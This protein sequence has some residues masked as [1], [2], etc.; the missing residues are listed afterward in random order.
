MSALQEL[1]GI[2]AHHPWY[3]DR[4]RGVR[5]TDWPLLTKADLYARLASVRQQPGGRGG[6]YYSRSG[7]TTT[8]QPLYFPTDVAENHEQ[9]RRLARR[10]VAD[11]VLTP[12]TVAVNICPIV[13]MYRAMEI[14]NEFCECC[15]A[16]VLPMAAI[17]G[18]AEIYEQAMLFAANTLLGMPSRMVAFGRYV[19][20]HQLH[21]RVDRVVFGGEFLQ[22]GKRR[23][24][25]DVFGVRHFSGVYGSAELGVVAWHPDLPEVPVYHFPKDILHVEIL[26]PDADGYGT[27]VATNL[28]RRRFPIVRYHTGDM[29]RIVGEGPDTISVE[30]RGRQSDS[31]LMGDNYHSLADFADLFQDLA[32]YQIQIH[33]DERQRKDVI[34]FCL[35]AGTRLATEGE[36]R[37]LAQRI[38]E[39][40]DGHE[41]MYH[42]EV[43]FVGPEGLLRSRDNLKTP[44]IVD[45]RGR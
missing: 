2:A 33:F 21:W 7:G 40:L 8:G 27:L 37:Q 14:F 11:G 24:L 19:Q 13:R 3:H 6:I 5:L 42:T 22:P 32:E 16:T 23:F 41:L 45:R 12:Q 1:L 29:G 38:C 20:E 17:A 35:N 34:R 26:A 28:V 10:L 31:F 36:R 15:G 4:E 9:R 43:A 18:D 30:L 25:H 39:R 44:A